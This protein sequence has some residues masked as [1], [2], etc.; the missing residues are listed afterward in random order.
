MTS[1]TRKLYNRDPAAAEAFRKAQDF[2]HRIVYG[3]HPTLACFTHTPTPKVEF[4]KREPDM[5]RYACD[6][7][8]SHPA[9]AKGC[10]LVQ[11]LSR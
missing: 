8:C 4:G 5:K 3:R 2:D 1:F 9:C 10:S 11:L 6:R 7:L